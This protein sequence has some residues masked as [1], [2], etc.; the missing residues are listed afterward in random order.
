MNTIINY[1]KCVKQKKQLFNGTQKE[2]T[3][4]SISRIKKKHL[5]TIKKLQKLILIMLMHILAWPN[6]KKLLNFM[7]KLL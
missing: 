6:V 5:N 1:K 2:E 4:K 7:I 3:F